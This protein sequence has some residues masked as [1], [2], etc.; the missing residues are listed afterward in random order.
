MKRKQFTATIR[1]DYLQLIE[2]LA[3]DLCLSVDSLLEKGIELVLYE[4]AERRKGGSTR[5]DT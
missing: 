2:K 5:K 4:Y 1:Q 3:D